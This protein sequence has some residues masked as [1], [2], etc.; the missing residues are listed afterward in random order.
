VEEFLKWA[1]SNKREGTYVRYKSCVT[2]LKDFFGDRKLGN[3]HPFLIEKYKQKRLSQG[4]KVAVNRE[5]SRLRTLYNLCMKCKKYEGENPARRF[6]MAPES[7]DRVRFLTDDEEKRLLDVCSEPLR[8]IVL[9]A[10]H[11]GVRA[12][13]EGLSPADDNG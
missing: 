9:V 6:Q 3:I 13:S 7:H 8:S 4:A 11:T 1:K 5:L 12:R 2:R 10:I